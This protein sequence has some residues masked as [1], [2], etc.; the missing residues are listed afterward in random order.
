MASRLL[1]L[2]IAYKINRLDLK[3]ANGYKEDLSKLERNDVFKENFKV[4]LLIVVLYG[5]N[6]L[7]LADSA[8]RSPG[9]CCEYCCQRWY[10]RCSL[11]CSFLYV[12]YGHSG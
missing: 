3:T 4:S 11:C 12:T 6:R 1:S 5:P 2:A 9:V 7:F 10:S 8:V